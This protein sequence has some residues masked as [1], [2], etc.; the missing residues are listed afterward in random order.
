MGGGENPK[1]LECVQ[2][3]KDGT[4]VVTEEHY[5]H[6]RKAADSSVYHVWFEEKEI[7]DFT[8]DGFPAVVLMV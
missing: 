7:S 4:E 8:S 1:R 3:N 2:E 5:I 6:Q